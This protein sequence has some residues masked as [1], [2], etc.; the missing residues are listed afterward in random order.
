MSE[1]RKTAVGV[2]ALVLLSL[3]FYLP[4][5][6]GRFVFCD[7]YAYVYGP[8]DRAGWYVQELD[9][10]GRPLTSQFLRLCHWIVR[11]TGGPDLAHLP[12]LLGVVGLMV[13]SFVWL[14]RC[15]TPA[16]PAFLFCI[17]LLTLPS[18][19]LCAAYLN[20]GSYGW[21]ALFAA[22]ALLTFAPALEPETKWIVKIGLGLAAW[23]L[24]Q[25]GFCLY[26][27]SALYYWSLTAA[28]L[29][30]APSADWR[31]FRSRAV[32]L[33]T[34]GLAAMVGYAVTFKLFLAV[35]GLP[36]L[37][38]V[39]WTDD[40]AS[41]VIWFWDFPLDSALSLW[42][43]PPAPMRNAS[44]MLWLAAAGLAAELLGALR[45]AATP[46]VRSDRASRAALVLTR[47]ALVAALIPVSYTF[48]LVVKE[49]Y[50]SYRTVL[51]LTATTTIILFASIIRLTSLLGSRLQ[52]PALTTILAA[53][54][55]T[56]LY[57]GG[58][59][60]MRL[61]ILP[62]ISEFEYVKTCLSDADRTRFAS[63][64]VIRAHICLGLA[65]AVAYDE[66]GT[67]STALSW[68][69]EPMVRRA[70]RE[71][72]YHYPIPPVTQSGPDETTPLPPDAF[73]ID[74][75]RLFRLNGYVMQ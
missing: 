69:I 31:A 62:R 32:P 4:T 36:P 44:W 73:V 9:Q 11:T 22:L 38:R 66:F 6:S 34:L 60:L 17:V 65:P 25:V 19:L 12:G 56:G 18:T 27:P 30:L 63:I 67:P 40:P 55:A 39:A 29:L 58:A 2:G 14:R 70:L 15:Q 50:S 68:T 75:R 53:A 57:L 5:L 21:A 72:H 20:C 28:A 37:P 64:H 71:L 41:K 61:V 49:S 74:M 42:L 3:A 54:A 51:A 23:L 1:S 48:N 47:W 59:N 46:A 35:R 33:L 7:D 45:S 8:P 10:S 24:M 16:V 26:Q 52:R 43:T 13:A